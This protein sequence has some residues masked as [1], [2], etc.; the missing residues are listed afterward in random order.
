MTVATMRWL[1]GA[2]LLCATATEARAQRAPFPADSLL[3]A[4]PGRPHAAVDRALR[5]AGFRTAGDPEQ[6]TR[7]SD[8]FR[9]SIHISYDRRRVYSLTHSVSCA[10]RAVC[11]NQFERRRV[12]LRRR[13]GVQP[14]EREPTM[15][16]WYNVRGRSYMLDAPTAGE[17]LLVTSVS[18]GF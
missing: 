15:V 8:S 4:L 16:L 2:L 11:A 9:E 6:Y 1:L 7:D 14:D 5:T 13:L 17:P 18:P 10:E 3:F 12:A